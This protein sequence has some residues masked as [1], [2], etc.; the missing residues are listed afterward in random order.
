MDLLKG[1]NQIAAD[2]ETIPKLTMA[3]PWGCFS[4]KVMPFGIVNDP[5]TFSRAIYLAMQRYLNEFASTY[6]DDITVFSASFEDHVS[7][8]EKVLQRLQ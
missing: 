7:H 2:E 1:F 4:Y 3:A 8:F 5:A 6:I